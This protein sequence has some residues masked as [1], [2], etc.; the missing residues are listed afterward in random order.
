MQKEEVSIPCLSLLCIPSTHSKMMAQTES[1]REC[2]SV[3]GV[4]HIYIIQKKK[5]KKKKEKEKEEEEEA[6]SKEQDYEV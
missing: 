1:R 3:D 6:T 5:N 2:I 4:A